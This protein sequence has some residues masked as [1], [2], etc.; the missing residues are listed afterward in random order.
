MF[1]IIQYLIDNSILTVLLSTLSTLTHVEPKQMSPFFEEKVIE[2]IL[3]AVF[4]KN[5]FEYLTSLDCN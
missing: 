5:K 4:L 3:A 1:L 2:S